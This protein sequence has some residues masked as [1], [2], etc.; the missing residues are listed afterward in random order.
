MVRPTDH[1]AYPIV[2]AVTESSEATPPTHP[3]AVVRSYLAS[4]DGRDPDAIAAHVT[5]DFVNEHTAALGTGCV[6]RDAYRQRLPGF[7]AD[8]VD[9]HYE[10]DDVIADGDRVAAFYTLRARWQGE[11]EVA[12]RGVQRFVVRGDHLAHRTDYWDSAVFLQQ[13]SADAR[14]ALAALGVS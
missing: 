2:A 1:T 5:D 11:A 12:V 3:V 8:M 10:V 6:G 7:L 9:L 4:F 13:A 14:A